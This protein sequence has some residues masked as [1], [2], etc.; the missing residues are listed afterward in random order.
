MQHRLRHTPPSEV[1]EPIV[2]IYDPED[3]RVNRYRATSRRVSSL[4]GRSANSMIA[5]NTVS[6]SPIW[7]PSA[8]RPNGRLAAVIGDR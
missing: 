8:T 1:G 7:R 2:G 5:S 3:E 6:Q 4:A